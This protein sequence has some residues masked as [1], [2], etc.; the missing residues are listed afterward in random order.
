MLNVER[1]CYFFLLCRYAVLLKKFCCF[2]VPI[3]ILFQHASSYVSLLRAL[4]VKHQ[5]L[6]G[7]ERLDFFIWQMFSCVPSST[8]MYFPLFFSQ[9]YLLEVVFS[10]RYRFLLFL[11]VVCLLTEVLSR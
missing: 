3:A 9:I 11:N 7:C 5:Y 4:V 1:M 8:V 2:D 10:L 6:T